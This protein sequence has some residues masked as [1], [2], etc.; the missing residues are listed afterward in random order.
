MGFQAWLGKTVVDSNLAP[1]KIT[2][3]MLMA[4]VIVGLLLSLLIK[5]KKVKNTTNN[6]FTSLTIV[7]LVPPYSPTTI[8]K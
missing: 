6:L 8:A 7:S 1:Y 5:N 3:H 2:I 4:L